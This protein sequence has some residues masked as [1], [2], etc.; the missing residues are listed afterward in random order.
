M[1]EQKRK[2]IIYGAL[3]LAIIYGTYNFWPS[4]SQV[5][6]TEKP[7]TIKPLTETNE[8]RPSGDNFIDVDSLKNI[9]WG[10]DPFRSKTAVTAPA[11]ASN[12]NWVLTGIIFN[13]ANPLAI[14]NKKTVGI[15]DIIDRAT[16]I[17]INRKDVTLE[18]NGKTYTLAV[19]KG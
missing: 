5:N 9:P 19:T 8:I 6:N 14:I 7:K 1:N 18:H 10:A 4:D 13:K 3:I 15:G 11:K 12:I 16:V 2:K 17:A